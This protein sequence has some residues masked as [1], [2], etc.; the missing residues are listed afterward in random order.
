MRRPENGE[1]DEGEGREEGG[2]GKRVHLAH[3]E[4]RRECVKEKGGRMYLLEGVLDGIEET[5]QVSEYGVEHER[6]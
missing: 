5:D 2:R 4:R 1:V 3:F 6:D